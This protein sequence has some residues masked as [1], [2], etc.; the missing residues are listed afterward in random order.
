MPLLVREAGRTFPGSLRALDTWTPPWAGAPPAPTPAV[1]AV[2][3]PAVELL[4]E[5]PDS[6]NAVAALLGSTDPWRGAVSVPPA[7][8]LT[9]HPATAT[10]VAA[11]LG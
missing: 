9:E 1:P 5:R 3:G 4:A 8:L 7:G 10:A 6:C 2:A 11:L